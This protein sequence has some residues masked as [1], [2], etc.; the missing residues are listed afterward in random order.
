MDMLAGRQQKIHSERDRK[1]AAAR[2]QRQIRRHQDKEGS[3]K[4]CIARGREQ[5]S[6]LLTDAFGDNHV[7]GLYKE[8]TGQGNP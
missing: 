5:T 7:P 6:F 4:S 8:E 1:L 2:Q 3:L